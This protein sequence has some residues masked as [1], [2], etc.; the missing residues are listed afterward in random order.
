M[1]A[2]ASTV[3]L[4]P[5][6]ATAS[7]L[8]STQFALERRYENVTSFRCFRSPGNPAVDTLRATETARMAKIVVI[9]DEV[10]LQQILAWNLRNAGH[11]V[12]TATHGGRRSVFV[13]KSL[14]PIC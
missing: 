1:L 11:E 14:R 6:Q 8:Q 10:D 13:A 12:Q 2:I 9:E 4:L 3:L 5:S 7:V